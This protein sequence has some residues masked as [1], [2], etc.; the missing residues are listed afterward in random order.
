VQ[1]LLKEFLL[2][3]DYRPGDR[4]PTEAE[5]G[6]AIGVSRSA[7]REALRSLQALGIVDI[8]QGHGMQLRDM[9]LDGLAEGL[10]FWTMLS[11]RDGT[12]AIRSIAYV[13]DAL[14]RSSISDVIG[15]HEPADIKQMEDAVAEMADR[16]AGGDYA[17]DADRRFHRALFHPLGNWVFTYV[18][19]AFWDVSIT[20]TTARVERGGRFPRLT[21]NRP[22]DIVANHRDILDA[23]R[24]GDEDAA[25]LA[26]QRHFDNAAAPEDKA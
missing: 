5:L 21:Q 9:S 2:A 20:I 25:R 4:L 8:R 10:A 15:R 19:D 18:L 13:R 7:T 11:E 6:A 24:R 12:Q 26:I 22:A 23:V 17:P 1:E 3:G 14:E 16:A